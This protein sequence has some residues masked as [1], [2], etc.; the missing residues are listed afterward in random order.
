[1]QREPRAGG[2]KCGR[3]IWGKIGDGGKEGKEQVKRRRYCIA[4]KI[5]CGVKGYGG[6]DWNCSDLERTPKHEGGGKGGRGG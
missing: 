3:L 4:I 2:A 6:H 5:N 1:M